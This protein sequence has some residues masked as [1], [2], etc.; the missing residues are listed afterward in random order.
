MGISCYDGPMSLNPSKKKLL[1]IEP[2]YGHKFHLPCAIISIQKYLLRI[3]RK[4]IG[5]SFNESCNEKLML[6]GDLTKQEI[7][8]FVRNGWKSWRHY[9]WCQEYLQEISR[10]YIENK[11]RM[12]HCVTDLAPPYRGWN[13]T[14][15]SNGR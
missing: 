12:S 7:N 15:W 1:L 8:E 14:Y 4:F 11:L 9:M 5:M 13:K 3:I 10:K 2:Q 6:K